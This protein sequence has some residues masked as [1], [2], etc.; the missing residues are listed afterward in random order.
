MHKLVILIEQVEDRQAFEERWPEFLHQVEAMPGLRR[1][2]TSR[3][4]ERLYGAR[5]YQQVHELFFDSLEAAREA[6]ASVPG[7]AAGRILQSMTGGRMALFFADHFED[8]LENIRKYQSG[9][10]GE[11]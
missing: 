6:M 3:V 5:A 7:R 9:A 2:V 4:E 1:E 8:E 10:E 11:A